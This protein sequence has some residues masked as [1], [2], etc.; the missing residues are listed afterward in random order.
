M[1]LRIIGLFFLLSPS[2]ALAQTLSQSNFTAGKS[3][4]VK[5]LDSGGA[6]VTSSY[7]LSYPGAEIKIKLFNGKPIIVGSIVGNYNIQATKTSDSSVSNLVVTVSPGTVSS[8]RLLD[9]NSQIVTAG[10]SFPS[11][12]RV[13]LMDFYGNSVPGGSVIFSVT[14]GSAKIAESSSSIVISDSNG[15]AATT[16]AGGSIAEKGTI[17]ATTI[18]SGLTKKVSFIET[19]SASENQA[20]TLE[21]NFQQTS[22]EFGQTFSLTVRPVT[23]TRTTAS[24]FSGVVS[25]AGYKNSLC[26]IPSTTPPTVTNIIFDGGSGQIYFSI[27]PQAVE[28]IYFKVSSPG[29][30][31]ICSQRVAVKPPPLG[32]G[33]LKFTQGPTFLKANQNFFPAIK[34]SESDTNGNMMTS[35]TDLIQ[36]KSYDDSNCSRLSSTQLTNNLV[37]A[38]GGY[39]TFP[40]IQST[41][42]RTLYI[43]AVAGSVSSSCSAALVIVAPPATPSPIVC[44]GGQH[45][46][47]R[48]CISNT[49]SCA[50]TN[51]TGTQTWNGISAYGRCNMATCSASFHSESNFCLSDTKSCLID[52]GSGQQAWNPTYS[53]FDSCSIL[54]CNTNFDL[55]SG[56]CFSTCST[57]QHHDPSTQAC[58][59]NTLDCTAE[60]SNSSSAT[61]TWD[62]ENLN[63]RSCSIL[64]CS[65]SFHIES[66]SCFADCSIEQTRDPSTHACLFPFNLE[67][68][69]NVKQNL[70][71]NIIPTG[72]AIPY[73]Y[74]L[75]SGVGLISS[76]G[77]YSSPDVGSSTIKVADSVG[78]F[79]MITINVFALDG[80]V[81][82]TYGNGQANGL[83]AF[84]ISSLAMAIPPQTSITNKKGE[85]FFIARQN[86]MLI[87]T[88][89]DQNGF[90][91]GSGQVAIP[92]KYDGGQ[93]STTVDEDGCVYFATHEAA[94]AFYL[95]FIIKTNPN[96]QQDLLFSY[97]T[98]G[99]S[100]NL[101][102][103]D[104]KVDPI[105]HTLYL[106]QS[107]GSNQVLQKI[108][109]NGSILQQ[110]HF[111]QVGYFGK[112]EFT[113]N[114]VLVVSGF[115]IYHYNWAIKIDKESFAVDSIFGNGAWFFAI[116]SNIDTADY[117][118]FGSSS[119]L[120]REGTVSVDQ[121]GNIYLSDLMTN[122]NT[123]EAPIYTADASGLNTRT[124]LLTSFGVF[125][126]NHPQLVIASA[127]IGNK[128]LIL[129]GQKGWGN[130]LKKFRIIRLNS[131]LSI[132]PEFQG[133]NLSTAI[134]G[135][136]G[137]EINVLGIKTALDGSIYLSGT[138][139]SSTGT[140]FISSFRLKSSLID[141]PAITNSQK[142]IEDGET[143]LLSTAG[144]Y[145]P[146]SYKIV[147]GEGSVNSVS[148]FFI[149]GQHSS[150]VTIR[151]TDQTGDSTDSIINYY[152]YS[153]SPK[154]LPTKIPGESQTF[155]IVG[156]PSG[157]V[158]LRFITNNSG[159]SVSGLTYTAGSTSYTLDALEAFDSVGNTY[160]IFVNVLY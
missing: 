107:N 125:D 12:L 49:K 134:S 115:N 72:G 41:T 114:S 30:T 61:K 35:A 154:T 1:F 159:G 28:P 117:I 146:Y 99:N 68:L 129:T 54:S 57:S 144:G 39:S 32:L 8:I 101:Y 152:K 22:I 51:G 4:S 69:K 9:G 18:I 88:K 124:S 21:I 24:N 79:K 90:L 93:Y 132:D 40:N 71:Y 36:I 43:K 37:S 160:P 109:V 65:T 133:F 89:I 83:S 34:V 105:D 86:G 46:E 119:S 140:T 47:N 63:Y 112:L 142:S 59:S 16:V 6:D 139:E 158:N 27:V 151:V 155:T 143:L 130:Q 77:T 80:A 126:L 10:S 128:L 29:L 118:F 31:G 15:V 38:V 85:T 53:S 3:V 56:A 97:A 123:G 102:L 13:K 17:T 110:T 66:N 137:E 113:K 11:P 94:S 84:S 62:S 19:T 127:S 73:V 156:N 108:N 25:V 26:S 98:V 45:I 135:P 52:N 121:K 82:R 157:P 106:L 136:N 64:S 122:K 141:G 42:G 14:S 60:A 76:T 111:Y 81:D 74:Q 23:S 120:T 104:I 95:P 5:V 48:A 92:S 147:S 153:L 150:H 67:S 33:F 149:P 58:E 70:S 7:S 78:N 20:T 87:I 131:D 138:Y 50:I 44:S 145:A 148:G 2:L 116:S 100:Y 75:I 91:A 96:L 103:E 55:I